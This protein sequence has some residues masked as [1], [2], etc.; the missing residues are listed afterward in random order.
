MIEL[1]CRKCGNILEIDVGGVFRSDLT[2][3]VGCKECEITLE[4][5]I[6][7]SAKL[8]SENEIL[9]DVLDKYDVEIESLHKQ[10]EELRD[11]IDGYIDDK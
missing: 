8:T 6:D 7:D 11:F 5:A 4:G 3:E 10:I 1:Q 2:I 9:Q